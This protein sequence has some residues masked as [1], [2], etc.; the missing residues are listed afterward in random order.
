MRLQVVLCPPS[1]Q[2]QQAQ[3]SKSATSS[4]SKESCKPRQPIVL[5]MDTKIIDGVTHVYLRPPFI[6][7]NFL[8]CK[9]REGWDWGNG[10]G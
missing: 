8:P 1:A 10:G 3:E 7:E 5:V 9:V 2:A 4:S 6:V